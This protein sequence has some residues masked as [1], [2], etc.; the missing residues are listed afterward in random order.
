MKKEEGRMQKEETSDF[1]ILPSTFCHPT[2]VTYSA[3]ILQWR[4]GLE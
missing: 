1:F 2:G 4:R 3:S